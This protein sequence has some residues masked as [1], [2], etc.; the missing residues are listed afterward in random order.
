MSTANVLF[1]SRIHDDELAVAGADRVDAPA[2][3]H[4]GM[5]L[6]G[7]DLIVHEGM[8]VAHVPQRHDEI[9]LDAFRP[10]RRRR[11]VALG[12]ALGPVGS[13]S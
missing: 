8:V 1:S 4:R 10:R 7:R 11:H 2:G 13:R 3:V 9:A 5:V 12:D 6:V